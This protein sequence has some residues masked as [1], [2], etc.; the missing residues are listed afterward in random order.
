MTKDHR[1]SDSN[2]SICVEIVG[3]KW[4]QT[5]SPVIVDHRG[6]RK[7]PKQPAHT[8][9]M[10]GALEQEDAWRVGV[11]VGVEAPLDAVLPLNGPLN[12]R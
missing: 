7:R 3:L 8:H 10:R 6:F 9:H 12:I 2:F 4:H 11:G 1:G 5:R